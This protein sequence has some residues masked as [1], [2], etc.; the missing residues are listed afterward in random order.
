M[1]AGTDVLDV[2]LVSFFLTLKILT[3]SSVVSIVNLEQVNAAGLQ[4][5]LPD[6]TKI[7]QTFNIFF[8]STVD[9]LNTEK[10]ETSYVMKRMI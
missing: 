10:D 3:L 1:P 8:N 9:E 5:V 4:K 7:A 2:V 6:D